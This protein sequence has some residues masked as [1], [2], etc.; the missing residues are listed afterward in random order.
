MHTSTEIL[1]FKFDDNNSRS[2]VTPIYQCSAFSSDSEYFYSRKNN[3][4][5]QE[6]EEIIKIL[7]KTKF[8]IAVATGMSALYMILDLLTVNDTLLVNKD[9]YGCSYKLFDRVCK[10]RKIKLVVLDLSEEKNLKN[11]PDDISMVIFE[12]PTNPFLK[13]IDIRKISD[14]AKKK[15]KKALVV[16]DNTWATS[17]FQKPLDFG[18]DISIHSCTKYYSGHSDVMGGVLLVNDQNIYNELINIRFYGGL[19]MTPYHAWL[20]RRSMQT[21]VLRINY[22]SQITKDI[23]QFLKTVPLIEKVYYPKI[24]NDQLKDYGGIVFFQFKKEYEDKY[25]LFRDSLKLFSTGTGMACVTSM[26]AQPYSGSHASLSE[27]EKIMMGLN[28]GLVRLCF[29][30][31]D[32]ND[33]KKDLMEAF[34]CV[35]ESTFLAIR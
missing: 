1:N 13:T 21:F 22:Q 33:I 15:N 4:N 3:P 11:I 31:E 7:E 10:Q 20:L 32:T 6:F 2:S 19:I 18:A 29:G 12:T 14:I 34:K 8:S 27:N 24:D 17:I 9:I 5:V 26:V 30:L 25:Q 35:E 16:C 28:K 23:Y